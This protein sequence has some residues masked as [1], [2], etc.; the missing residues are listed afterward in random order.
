MAGQVLLLLL[1][2]FSLQYCWSIIKVYKYFHYGKFDSY[3]RRV[4]MSG[5]VAADQSGLL[6]LL[7][8]LPICYLLYQELLA[9]PRPI[10]YLLLS[11][12]LPR[13]IC[14]L[15]LSVALPRAI[16]YLL[17]Q[18]D[19]CYLLHLRDTCYLLYQELLAI[20][21]TKSYLLLSIPRATCKEEVLL[22]LLALPGV[23][24][25]ST[26]SYLQSLEYYS[27]ACEE[28]VRIKE[29]QLSSIL[30]RG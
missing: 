26:K 29:V 17:Y 22:F 14:Y 28:E 4:D 15:I 8:A 25:C 13:A 30:C 24:H 21:Y 10:C 16:S 7:L 6:G 5:Q 18:R 9:I 2:S 1:S 11:L 27:R 20:C 3:C 12:A 19:T 23:F